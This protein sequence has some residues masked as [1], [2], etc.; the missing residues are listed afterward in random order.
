MYHSITF[1]NP[2]DQSDRRN[3]YDDWHLVP[4]SRLLFNPPSVKTKYIDIP[5]A[6]SHI[7]LTDVLTNGPVYNNREGSFDF[8]V[9]N[10]YGDWAERYSNIMNYL[11]GRRL[12]AILEDDPNNYYIGRF[13][14][15]TWGS[16]TSWSTITISYNVDPYKRNVTW[17]T[18]SL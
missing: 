15:E 12:R 14:V 13:S 9:L 16:E 10:D 3:S 5:G 11:H 7:D 8:Y 18:T 4:K 2:N 17:N 6:D 1:I